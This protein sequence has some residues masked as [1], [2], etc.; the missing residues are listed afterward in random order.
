MAKVIFEFDIDEEKDEIR[1]ALDG[2]KWKLA[3]F[4]LDQFLR[5]TTKHD[6]SIIKPGEPATN[7]EY[8]IADKIRDEIRKI[9]HEY[10]IL[11]D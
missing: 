5:Q 4:D 2:Y 10:E 1:M 9:L 11:L 3:M 6:S 8:L 7:D